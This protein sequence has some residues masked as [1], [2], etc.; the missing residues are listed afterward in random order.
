M[1]LQRILT[2]LTSPVQLTDPWTLKSLVKDPALTV[3]NSTSA[4]VS[5]SE[6]VYRHDGTTS[7]SAFS[8]MGSYDSVSV[9]ESIIAQKD[10]ALFRLKSVVNWQ[11]TRLDYQSVYSAYL[12]GAMDEEEFMVEAEVFATEYKDLEFSVIAQEIRELSKLLDFELSAIDYADYFGVEHHAVIEAMSFPSIEYHLN[13]DHVA[14]NTF[15]NN[16]GER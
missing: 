5:G 2:T 13:E 10:I 8:L 11:K 16:A 7:G 4:W 6:I 1:I 14:L 3:I 12:L 9:F 15:I